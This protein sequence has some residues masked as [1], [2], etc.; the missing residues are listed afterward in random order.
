M[1]SRANSYGYLKANVATLPN[2]QEALNHVF[3]L[4][5][6][7]QP[8]GQGPYGISPN[9][10]T[11]V[12]N[13][14]SSGSTFSL[15]TSELL[16]EDD[17][18]I[19]AGVVPQG[20][21]PISSKQISYT[22]TQDCPMQP[23]DD[24]P[25]CSN[26]AVRI[27]SL[28]EYLA[29]Q[30]SAPPA[31]AVYTQLMIGATLPTALNFLTA[32]VT[33][34]TPSGASVGTPMPNYPNYIDSSLLL[35][36]NG[37]I[38]NSATIGPISNFTFGSASMLADTIALLKDTLSAHN[39]DVLNYFS[40]NPGVNSYVF[41]IWQVNDTC[42]SQKAPCYFDKTRVV[43]R[44]P[45]FS[46]ISLPAEECDLYFDTNPDLQNTFSLVYCK[47]SLK[48]SLFL[49]QNEPEGGGAHAGD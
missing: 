22:F 40:S 47:M 3:V 2:T 14:S 4:F 15:W 44:P 18:A 49:T 9:T 28:A 43:D 12:G 45:L 5:Q 41:P 7:G 23:L 46:C 20:E 48:R 8:S 19:V 34:Q 32:F 24:G 39:T 37:L 11:P 13:W 29:Y 38:F 31:G 26:G 17:Y 21:V 35:F 6:K 33:P 27:I 42:Q 10:N 30:T 36:N 25:P 16:G 1:G